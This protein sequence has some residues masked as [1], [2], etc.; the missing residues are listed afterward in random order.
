MKNTL[1][2]DM[3]GV[4]A[5]FN[6]YAYRVHGFDPEVEYP[7]HLWNQIAQNDRLYRELKKTPYA[8]DLVNYCR[9]F[10]RMNKMN[11]YF[12]TAVPKTNK[13]HW[14]F[15]D[16]VQWAQFY[17][18]DIPVHFGPFSQ[19]KHTHCIPGDILIDDR[20]SN[21]NEWIIAGGLGILHETFDNTI[22]CLKI[23]ESK[24]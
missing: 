22:E 9:T 3:D 19:N 17:F 1:Y 23:Y 13:I 21:I 11:L 7:D 4:V 2:L 14:A 18:T 24:A 6:E 8:D 10:T 15:Y 12:L 20:Q 16:K 5:D